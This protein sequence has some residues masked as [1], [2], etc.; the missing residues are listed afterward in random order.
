MFI[1][2]QNYKERLW[3]IIIL[4]GIDFQ[5][6]LSSGS[7]Q[8]SV[9]ISLRNSK[10]LIKRLSCNY[11]AVNPSNNTWERHGTL[12]ET[13]LLSVHE[14][15]ASINVAETFLITVLCTVWN[16]LGERKT[17]TTSREGGVGGGGGWRWWRR[18]NV[19]RTLWPPMLGGSLER[20]LIDK[21]ATESTTFSTHN[22]RVPSKLWSRSIVLPLVTTDLI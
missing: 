17:S 2:F 7:S 18:R 15:N 10:E 8:F 1:N 11:A 6:F 12:F 14:R 5:T 21:G 13:C 20:N 3:N 16:T 22:Q 4:P 9:P 19:V